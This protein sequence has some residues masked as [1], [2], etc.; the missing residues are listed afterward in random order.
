VIDAIHTFVQAQMALGQMPGLSLAV[1]RDG[2]LLVEQGY[3]YADLESGQPMTAD[4][5][6]IIGSTTK[7][8]T[9]AGVVQLVHEGKLDLDAPVQ[10]YVPSFHLADEAH[11]AQVTLRHLLTHTAGLPATPMDGPSFVPP[12]PAETA[13]EYIEQLAPVY[14]LWP[15]GTRWLYANDGYVV[16]GRAIETASGMSYPEY[17][18][19]RIFAPLGMSSARFPT[20]PEP[21]PDLA[22]PYDYGADG[23][24]FRSYLAFERTYAPGFAT[25]NV[26]DAITW[27]GSVLEGGRGVIPVEEQT[28]PLVSVPTPAGA[29]E[30]HYG[31]G[32]MVAKIGDSTLIEHGGSVITMGSDFVVLPEERVAVAAL[33]NSGTLAT[34]V[35]ARGVALLACGR[36]PEATYPRLEPNAEWDRS[37]APRL[38]GLYLTSDPTNGLSS[39]LPIEWDGEVLR[40][41]TYPAAMGY[42]PGD[43]F[44]APAGDTRFQMRGRGRTGSMATF[45]IDG[46]SV[47][48]DFGGAQIKKVASQIHHGLV[49]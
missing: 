17:M 10:R 33:A 34:S 13:E 46:P 12:Y 18:A 27:V 31:L 1:L 15:V 28:R 37:L 36:E 41:R 5:A 35:I 47:I 39:P 23:S 25:M 4:T 22:A 3:G 29:P 43:I 30:A 6:I 8:M 38:A 21:E 48:A 11:A 32:W 19:E 9:A 7:A 14:P 16:A 26:R 20:S 40:G 2:E 49:M 24:A 42:R 45:T 44:L